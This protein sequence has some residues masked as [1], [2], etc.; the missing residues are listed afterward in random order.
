MSRVPSDAPQEP[1]VLTLGR[2]SVVN[3]FTIDLE[4]WFHVSNFDRVIRPEDWATCPT[5]LQETVPRLLDLLAAHR[6]H[7]TVFALGWVARH[8]PGLIRRIAAEGHELATHG[9][10]HRLMTRLSPEQFRAQMARSVDAIQQESGQRVF[11]HRAPA[12]SFRKQT[13]WAVAILLEAGLQYDSS[14]FPFGN[15][16]DAQLCAS[17]LPCWLNDHGTGAIAEYPLS[18][19]Q[20]AGVNIP[21]AG[22]G[23]FRLLPY[24]FVRWAIQRLNA[25]GERVI[26]YIHPWEIDPHQPRVAQ[27]T[28]LARF[29]HYHQLER[30]EEKL[31]RLLAD[32]RFGSFR[33]VFW[34]ERTG[35]YETV[36]QR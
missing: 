21:I 5:R 35:R 14:I 24:A 32:F 34:S 26:M 7:A 18:M 31:S 19:F 22:G 16:L 23:Y 6:I 13:E 10:E 9:D 12:Y 27:A 4:D 8:F 20:V 25:Q 17:R 3:V 33:E 1:E 36:P 30:T 28:W 29:R 2:T 15:R 11:G